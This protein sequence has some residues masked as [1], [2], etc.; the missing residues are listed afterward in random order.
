MPEALPHVRVELA[1]LPAPDGQTHTCPLTQ[2]EFHPVPGPWLH[3]ARTR[4]PVDVETLAQTFSEFD[5][6]RPVALEASSSEAAPVAWPAPFVRCFP[7]SKPDACL[8]LGLRLRLAIEGAPEA[9]TDAERED[10]GAL[11]LAHTETC[12]AAIGHSWPEYASV[13]AAWYAVAA[14]SGWALP[15]DA[16]SIQALALDHPELA[17]HLGAQTELSPLPAAA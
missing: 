10:L 7:L 15:T 12:R 9:F 11:L 14:P 6:S 13:L 3:C 16:A 2:L 17:A 4:R 1:W 8:L 5:W